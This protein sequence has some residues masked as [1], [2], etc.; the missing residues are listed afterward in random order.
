MARVSEEQLA[1]LYSE[2]HTRLRCFAVHLVRNV[3]DADDLVQ[4]AFLRM[5]DYLGKGGT[6]R[7]PVSF[8]FTTVRNLARDLCRKRAVD[9]VDRSVDVDDTVH[10]VSAPSTE[11][12][13]EV[14]HVLDTMCAGIMQLPSRMREAYVL[15]RIFGYSHAEAGQKLGRAANTVREQIRQ[16]SARLDVLAA[17]FQVA[18]RR[19]AEKAADRIVP[20]SVKERACL[21][22]RARGKTPHEIAEE[23]KISERAVNR[24]M[25]SALRKLDADTHVLAV[26]KAIRFGLISL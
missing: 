4:Q 18:H 21:Q 25:K 16:A 15:G 23:L 1:A 14:G 17:R 10:D 5:C 9:L 2:N 20:L 19:R 3:D 12:R 13:V 22:W 26:V 8:L 7:T 6:I 24:H 11:Q